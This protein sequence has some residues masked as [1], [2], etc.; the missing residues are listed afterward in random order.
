MRGLTNSREGPYQLV[1][2]VSR[3]KTAAVLSALP[4]VEEAA[5]WLPTEESAEVRSEQPFSP[6]HSG[7]STPDHL[8]TQDSARPK[9]YQ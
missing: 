5:R 6:N 1:R 8:S 9:A 4:L 3:A 2:A 7:L